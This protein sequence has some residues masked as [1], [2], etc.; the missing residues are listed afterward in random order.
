MKPVILA[1]IDYSYTSPAICVWDTSLPYKFENLRFYGYYDKKKYVGMH[2]TNILVTMHLLWKTPEERFA[3]IRDWAKAV[4]IS[5]GVTHVGL[6]GYALGSRSGMIF[7]IAENTSLLKQ[8]I[9]EL[10]LEFE[11]FPP[12]QVKKNFTGKGNAKK[13]PMI[14]HFNE[15]HAVK[16]GQLIGADLD[17]PYMKPGDDLCDANA[18]MQCHSLFS[19]YKDK[20]NE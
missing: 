12:S 3:N 8:A 18:I 7:Q 13:E 14:D 16:I 10:G 2:G 5:E 9:V 6:E 1:G 20:Q 19:E 4:L 11:I 17:K 15:I